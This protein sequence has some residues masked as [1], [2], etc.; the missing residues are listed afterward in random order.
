[1]IRPHG[2]TRSGLRRPGGGP[3]VVATPGYGWEA[4]SRLG[5]QGSRQFVITPL[6]RDRLVEIEQDV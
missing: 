1:M 2:T 5:G 6:G 3:G 4:A